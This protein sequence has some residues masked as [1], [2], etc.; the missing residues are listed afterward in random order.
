MRRRLQILFVCLCACLPSAPIAAQDTDRAGITAA[1]LDYIEGFYTG[2]PA[3]MERALH[4]DLA[5]RIMR[6]DGSGKATL[7]QM[8][9]TQLVGAARSRQGMTPPAVQQKDVTIFDV[10]GNTATAKIVANQWVDYLHLV[11]WEGRWVI[12]NVLWEMKPRG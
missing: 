8:S 5:K 10:F 1:A 11:K 12:V 7:E 6:I 2:D 4:P 3:R 9:S